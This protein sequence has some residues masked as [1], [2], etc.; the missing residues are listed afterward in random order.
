M[1]VSSCKQH[2]LNPHPWHVLA[3]AAIV[4]VLVG[5]NITAIR[6]LVYVRRRLQGPE[7]EVAVERPRRGETN[8]GKARVGA[9]TMFSRSILSSL[10]ATFLDFVAV[11]LLVSGLAFLPWAATFFGCLIGGATNFGINRVW[12]FPGSRGA[13]GGQSLRYSVVSLSSAFLNAGGVALLLLVPTMDYRIA[14]LIARFAVYVAW[15]YPLNRDYV[16]PAVVRTGR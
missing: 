15:N 8:P 6:R 4:F 10:V 3:V 7:G 2:P 1:A 16:F 9:W 12:A 13:V 11:T 5:S 14:W